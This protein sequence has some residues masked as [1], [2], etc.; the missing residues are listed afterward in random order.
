MAD[1]SM[2]AAQGA[3]RS[4]AELL[5]IRYHRVGLVSFSSE[6]RL[7]V[8]LTTNVGQ[9]IDAIRSLEPEG[10]T[11]IAAA[12][13]MADKQLR[14][15]GRPDALPVI[16]LLTDG[17]HNQG[18]GD[19]RL[20]AAN[21]RDRGVQI[22]TVGLGQEIDGS[23][24]EELAGQ[25]DRSFFAPSPD[26]LFPI[27]REILRVVVSSL[28]GNLV[29]DD[30]VGPDFEVV[31]DTVRPPAL[32]RA[33][34]LQWGRSLLPSSGITLTYRVQPLRAGRLR[35]AGAYAEYTD[36]DG[37]RRRWAFPA[38]EV[39]VIAPTS[40]PTPAAT[41]TA[42]WP[43]VYLPMA[44]Q[45]ACVSRGTGVD[46]ALVIDTSSSMAGSKLDQAKAAALT[47]VEL[48]RLP[49]DQ[50]AVFGFDASPQ[51]L[52]GLTDRRDRLETAIRALTPG[53]GT[54]IDAALSASAGELVFG[55]RRR[56]ENR[57]VIVLLTDGGQGGPA[58][59]A[60]AA[61]DRVKGLGVTVYA[62]GLGQDEDADLLRAVA[63]SGAYRHAP[64]PADLVEIYRGI[65]ASLPCD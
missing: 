36:G 3:A 58:S 11:N 21:A 61:A 31:T 12:L 32:E 34:G 40:T 15:A 26:R 44:L 20:T 28:A 56:H 30:P 4:F 65:A 57:P 8:G 41:A 55:P 47:F 13:E 7:D 1:A 37:V 48:L 45:A 60:L 64:G 5:D 9:V 50:G 17:R 52:V 51:L 14:D 62:I 33:D 46:V 24:L 35:L 10:E 53:Q 49:R 54:R 18:E 39:E 27:Y 6:A 25:P 23:L 2:A 43:R 16:V 38:P 19:P 59:D 42:T 29:I 63:S 22:Y